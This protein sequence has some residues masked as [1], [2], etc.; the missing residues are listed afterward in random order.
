[1][2]KMSLIRID[3]PLCEMKDYVFAS[4]YKF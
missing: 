2:I 1:M 4:T 3:L